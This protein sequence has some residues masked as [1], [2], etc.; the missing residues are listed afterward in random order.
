M[1]SLRAVVLAVVLVGCSIEGTRQSGDT[2]LSTREC[3]TGLVCVYTVTGDNRC[4]APTMWS[5][6]AAMAPTDRP[7]ATDTVTPTD[8][9]PTLDLPV[10]MDSPVVMDNGAPDSGVTLDLGVVM[11]AATD[12]GSASVDAATD[13]ATDTVDGG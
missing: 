10:G 6:D 1:A 5:L 12:A 8:S 13:A 7:L 2:C 4:A 9:T 3:A 11:D